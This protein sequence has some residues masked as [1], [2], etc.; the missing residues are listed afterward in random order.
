MSGR[1]QT[2][3]E[4]RIAPSIHPIPTKQEWK[5]FSLYDRPTGFRFDMLLMWYGHMHEQSDKLTDN[6]VQWV[7]DAMSRMMPGCTFV[8]MDE[9]AAL[10]FRDFNV[11]FV[12]IQQL[13]DRGAG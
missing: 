9:G 4:G 8:A 2:R 12:T 6:V 3:F 5:T 13:I 11:P 7:G 1:N 10:C